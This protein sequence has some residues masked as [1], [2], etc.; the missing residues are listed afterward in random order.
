MQIIVDKT[1]IHLLLEKSDDLMV[2]F[3]EVLKSQNATVHEEALL[4]VGAVAAG[5]F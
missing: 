1:P 3:I 4:A 5:V 2:L